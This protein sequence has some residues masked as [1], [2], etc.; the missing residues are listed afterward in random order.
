MKYEESIKYKVGDIVFVRD[1]CLSSYG[2]K[3][4]II[5]DCG[6][7][8][9]YI[10][11]DNGIIQFVGSKLI[12]KLSNNIDNLK[13]TAQ[14]SDKISFIPNPSISF[15][16]DVTNSIIEILEN[17]LDTLK[18]IHSCENISCNLCEHNDT[19]LYCSDVNNFKW[20][21][22]DRATELLKKLKGDV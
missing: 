11:Y 12:F 7:N 15:T 2:K 4:T 20:E 13:E 14:N 3:G 22:E 21:Y 5:E 6:D 10:E 17:T 16:T 8:F 19:G 18:E 1:N 9:Y